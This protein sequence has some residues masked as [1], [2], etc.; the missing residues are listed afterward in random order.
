ML[1]VNNYQK[2]L[3]QLIKSQIHSLLE[4]TNAILETFKSFSEKVV[5]KIIIWKAQRVPQ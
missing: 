4:T 3:M 1:A 2:M 5:N